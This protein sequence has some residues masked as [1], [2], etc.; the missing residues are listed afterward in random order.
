MYQNIFLSDKS[1]A[2]RESGDVWHHL[3]SSGFSTHILNVTRMY[4]MQLQLSD[5][6]Q[7]CFSMHHFIHFIYAITHYDNG[8]AKHCWWVG[9][10]WLP[11]LYLIPI[12]YTDVNSRELWKIC[13][14]H[15]LLYPFQ[16]IITISQHVKLHNLYSWYSVV[17]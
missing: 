10:D 15:F 13:H 8:G 7:H 16:S 14:N 9:G 4:L 12:K 6:Y 5:N 3:V 17:K 2:L 11:N 1:T